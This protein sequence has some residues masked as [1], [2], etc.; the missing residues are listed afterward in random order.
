MLLGSM[1]SYVFITIQ[2]FNSFCRH[3]CVLSLHL[4]CRTTSFAVISRLGE[5]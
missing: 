1:G 4:F 3:T 5:I 2:R